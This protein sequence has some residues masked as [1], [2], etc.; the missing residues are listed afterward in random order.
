MNDAVLDL[1]GITKHYNGRMVLDNISARV[2]PGQVIGLVGLNG[3][4]KTT[5]LETT[6]GYALPDSGSATVLGTSSRDI[7]ASSVA[8][9]VGFVP[10]QE[11][12][13]SAYRGCDYLALIAKFYRVWHDETVNRLVTEWSI[14]IDRRISRM[15]L[16]ERQKLAIASALGHHP[17]LIVL[18]EPVASLDPL[19]RRQFLGEIVAI[20]ADH[21]ATVLFSTHL[22]TDLERVAE[23]IWL[24]RDGRLIVDEDL[25]ALKERH[26]ASLEDY[27]LEMH[28]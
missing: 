21:D 1:Q 10:Q 26:P 11:E 9:K 16:G 13:L 24:L 3:A 25:D 15:S 20:A 7:G 8:A 12:L 23:R 18:D 6:L 28:A 17:E 27:F 5:L 14:P 19:A 2:Q 22:V 4:G